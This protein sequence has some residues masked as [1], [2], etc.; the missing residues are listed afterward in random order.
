MSS[1]SSTT[2]STAKTCR[3]S[4][5]LLT[6]TFAVAEQPLHHIL[7][8]SQCCVIFRCPCS[9]LRKLGDVYR[10]TCKWQQKLCTTPTKILL[11][12]KEKNMSSCCSFAVLHRYTCQSSHG[13]WCVCGKSRSLWY[14]RL[15]VH[16][17]RTFRLN[18]SKILQSGA[19][20]RLP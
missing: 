12:E 15:N 8:S 20:P 3:S 1:G 2:Q 6:L 11:H 19:S 16:A 18:Y 13:L 5:S 17:W 4:P 10:V 7:I 14:A 9:A